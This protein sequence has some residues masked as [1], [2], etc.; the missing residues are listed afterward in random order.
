MNIPVAS[1]IVFWVPDKRF[2]LT[3]FKGDERDDMTG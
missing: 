1:P 2:K 3:G